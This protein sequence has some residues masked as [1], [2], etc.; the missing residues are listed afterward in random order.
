MEAK[1]DG[2]KVIKTYDQLLIKSITAQNTHCVKSVCTRSYS[3]RHFPASGL[4]TERYS[5]F[6]YSIRMRKNT[7]EN[8]SEYGYFLLS[9]SPYPV[10]MRENADENNSEYGHFFTQ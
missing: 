1:F 2:Q 9:I 4:N 3:G 7:D 8:N 10:R 5:M 6:P